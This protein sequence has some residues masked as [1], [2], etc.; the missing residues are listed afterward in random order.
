MILL[1]EPYV[2]EEMKEYLEL[3]QEAVLRNEM[4]VSNVDGRTWNLEDSASMAERM[5][6]G[7]RVYTVSEHSLSWIYENSKS[8]ELMHTIDCMKNK[9]MFRRLLKE[10]NPD[11]FFMEISLTDLGNIKAKELPLPVVLK[12]SV[13]FFSVGVF[14]IYTEDD[15]NR[16]VVAIRAQKNSIASEYPDR[17]VDGSMFIIEEYIDGTEFAID[18]YFDEYGNVVVLNIMQHDFATQNDVSDRLY[19]TSKE[20]IQEYLQMFTTYFQESNHLFRAKNFPFHAEVRVKGEKISPIEYNPMRFA[21]WCCTDITYFAFGFRTYDYYLQNKKPDWEELLKGKDGKIYALVVLNK[22]DDRNVVSF[23]YQCL[24]S[25]F[26]EVLSL[27]KI[28]YHKYPLYGFLFT[29]TSVWNRKELERIV[30]S[31]LLEYIRFQS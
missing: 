17:V 11:F 7:E 4:S 30:K 15:W 1:D 24:E 6:K 22:V 14:T 19:Y 18:A 21:G 13:G 9:V 12:P 23:D 20:I 25:E 5:N 10:K 27:R 29:E 2:S 8:E 3:S 31:D 26:E 16:A 28:D